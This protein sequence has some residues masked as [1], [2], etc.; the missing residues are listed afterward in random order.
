[1]NSM[2]DENSGKEKNRDREKESR[3]GGERGGVQGSDVVE[4]ESVGVTTGSRSGSG[5]TASSLIG[6]GGG[7]QGD[8]CVFRLSES[9]ALV[10]A[11]EILALSNRYISSQLF[12]CLVFSVLLCCVVLCCV[13][14]YVLSSL[15]TVLSCPVL[16]VVC[17]V[18]VYVLSLVSISCIIIPLYFSTIL[19]FFI[20]YLFQ[21][22][23]FLFFFL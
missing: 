22:F 15:V 8:A 12:S 3:E 20:D 21:L 2:E 16:C 4:L 9:M 18:R 5:M 14:S 7:V 17:T 11:R 1:M 6:G 10:H 19:Y 13:V 23:S